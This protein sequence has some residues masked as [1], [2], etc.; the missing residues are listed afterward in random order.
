MYNKKYFVHNNSIRLILVEIRV[1]RDRNDIL[2]YAIRAKRYN[3][4]MTLYYYMSAMRVYCLC[5]GCTKVISIYY[6][7]FI[8][9]I[10]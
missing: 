5:Y 7:V 10:S 8:D 1:V 2:F 6:L 4:V 3:S 9:L